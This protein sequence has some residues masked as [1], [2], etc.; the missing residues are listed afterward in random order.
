MSPGHKHVSQSCLA[1]REVLNR[2]GDKWSVLIVQLLGDG[3][4]RFSELRRTIEGISQRMLTLTLKGL[5]RDGLI[6]RTVY[7]DVPLRVEYELTD[8]GRTLR[9]PIQA[10]AEWAQKNREEIQRSR[11]RYDANSTARNRDRIGSLPR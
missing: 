10:L 6:T 8:L 2:V 4:R 5:E 1:V 7:P 3:P 11:N 9:K